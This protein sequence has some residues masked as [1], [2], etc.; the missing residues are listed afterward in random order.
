MD[1]YNKGEITREQFEETR[2]LILST[3]GFASGGLA[4]GPE[5][6]YIATLHG[7][8]YV[9]PAKNVVEIDTKVWSEI[10]EILVMLLNT[11]G[12]QNK[13]NKKVYNI[14]EQWNVE[15]LPQQRD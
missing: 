9:F 7:K 14:L 6:G 8:E 12:T 1:A 3:Q 11:A 13:T 5:T 4:I 15:G 2:K 10:K